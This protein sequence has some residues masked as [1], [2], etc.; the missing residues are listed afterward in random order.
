MLPR[1]PG[2]WPGQGARGHQAAIPSPCTLDALQPDLG[3]GP[4]DA[5]QDFYLATITSFGQAFPDAFAALPGEQLF[6]IVVAT[7]GLVVFALVLALVEQVRRGSA[8]GG[9]AGAGTHGAGAGA[10]LTG[11]CS[12]HQ[13]ATSSARLMG[14]GPPGP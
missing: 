11:R 2:T 8:G 7:G 9:C 6:S 4:L 1:S 5:W 3:D 13:C 14:P 10:L 12:H